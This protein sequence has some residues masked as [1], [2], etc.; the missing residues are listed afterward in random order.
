LPIAIGLLAA[1]RKL[2]T[3][4]LSEFAILGELSLDG[5]VKPMRGALPSAS[6]AASYGV[7]SLVVPLLNA[8]EATLV[9]GIDVYGVTSLAEAC[10]LV[11]GHR[12]GEPCRI[13][14]E[15]I[16]AGARNDE[17]DLAD[18]RGQ[19]HAKRAL[20][21]T[22]AGAHN[23]LLIG[24]PGSGKTML[25]RRLATIL[26]DMTLAEAI[27]T[28]RIHSVSGLLDGRAM[29]ATRPFRAPHHTISDAALIGG[30]SWPKPGEASL[31]HHGVLFLDELPEFRRNVLEALRQPLE[32]R[33]VTVCRAHL[34]LAFPAS[35]LL[36]A[37]MNPC[38]CGFRGDPR[39][40]CVCTEGEIRRYRSRISGPLLDRIDI[41]IEV[42]AVPFEDL[43]AGKCG[44]PSATVRSRVNRARQIQ[45]TRFR[46]RK[47][48]S[49]AQMNSRDVRRYCD[50]D[51]RGMEL[52]KA[53]VARFGLSARAYVR[54]LKVARTIADLAGCERVES[55][56]V[57]E[58]IHYRTLDRQ[59]NA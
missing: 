34:S 31:A 14:V 25:A 43:S 55:A 48:L 30:G 18:V 41:Q 45:L 3:E 7:R 2:P 29:I 6:A 19:E 17:I 58:A 16:F 5:R 53:A 11:S 56:H 37:A 39:R 57:A 32:D 38:P 44:D 23:V 47:T 49:N 36:A 59:G 24:P 10:A 20:E 13:D 15:S 40:E 9:A 26:P 28:T 42:P 50:L 54:T 8:P 46:C 21:V 12:V 1:D 33:R 35:F 27:E 51:A 22:A 52:L 4:R